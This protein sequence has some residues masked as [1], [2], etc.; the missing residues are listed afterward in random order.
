MASVLSI[1]A[2]SVS[3]DAFV[4]FCAHYILAVSTQYGETTAAAAAALPIVAGHEV[5]VDTSS[6]SS[7]HNRALF[8]LRQAALAVADPRMFP[9]IRGALLE[10]TMVDATAALAVPGAEVIRVAIMGSRTPI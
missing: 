5:I 7:P 10:A 8:S 4:R 2:D 1:I 9:F 6:S 3:Q